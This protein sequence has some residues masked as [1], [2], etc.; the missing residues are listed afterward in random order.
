MKLAFWRKKPGKRLAQFNETELGLYLLERVRQYVYAKRRALA[1]PDFARRPFSPGGA[2]DF[3]N[4]GDVLTILHE[5]AR[6]FDD[7]L[8]AKDALL[9]NGNLCVWTLLDRW[10]DSNPL[11][12]WPLIPE[13]KHFPVQSYNASP[14]IARDIATDPPAARPCACCE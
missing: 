8:K 13:A 2:A 9:V 3:D 5:K 7:K 1:P 11:A 14:A 12:F 6:D 4:W 10:K